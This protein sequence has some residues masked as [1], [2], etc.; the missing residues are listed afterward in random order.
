MVLSNEMSELTCTEFIHECWLDN[1]FM[2]VLINYEIHIY[3]TVSHLHWTFVL[4][5][6]VY[7]NCNTQQAKQEDQWYKYWDDDLHVGVER[8]FS[9]VRDWWCEFWDYSDWNVMSS[10]ETHSNCE[11][12]SDMPK[13][14]SLVISIIPYRLLISP[15]ARIQGPDRLKAFINPL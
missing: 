1:S 7:E 8:H 13:L 9:R 6:P 3:D 4:T 2:Q 10:T 15:L 11:V 14:K 5:L 12:R